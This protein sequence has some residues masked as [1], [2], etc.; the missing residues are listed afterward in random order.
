LTKQDV[1][2]VGS[3]TAVYDEAGNLVS[4]S[5]PRGL[6]QTSTYGR[7]GNEKT[8]QYA[9]DYQGDTKVVASWNIER[10]QAGRTNSISGPERPTSY[11]YDLQGRL[12]TAHDEFDGG[13]TNRSYGFDTNSNQ[14]SRITQVCD[15][16]CDGAS[17]TSESSWIFDAAN[18]VQSGSNGQ[19]GGYVY[20]GLGRQT[21]IPGIDTVTGSGDLSIAYYDNDLVAS[22]SQNVATS[23][24]TLDPAGRRLNQTLTVSGGQ[25]QLVR[26]YTDESDNPGWVTT[27]TNESSSV[28][29]YVS[30]IGGDLAA[31]MTDG[32]LVLNIVDPLGNVA[33]TLTSEGDTLTPGELGQWDEYGNRLT[34]HSAVS[35]PLT[36]GWLGGK[37]RA[38]D[39]TTGLVLMGSRLYNPVTG[40]FTSVDPVPGGNTTEYGYPQDPINTMDLDGNSWWSR[41]WQKVVAVVAVVA[42]ANAASF[43]PGPV[44]MISSGVAAVSYASLGQWGAVAA[45]A[46]AFIPGGKIMAMALKD[47]KAMRSIMSVQASSRLVGKQSKLFGVGS[48][49]GKTLNRG[50]GKAGLRIG[51][52]KY[53]SK[54]SWRA[55][56]RNN[57]H[58]KTQWLVDE[59]GHFFNH[60]SKVRWGR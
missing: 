6:T 47:G 16:A 43:I 60:T 5:T 25:T 33:T 13:C 36:Y 11:T 18:R 4:Q 32:V 52:S 48:K 49:F 23:T 28:T 40:L 38:V 19:G 8:L 1:S 10:D 15:D 57:P 56:M 30:S 50:G 55:G 20:D 34:A 46:V 14:T 22:T 24:F 31:S 21:V 9:V 54:A 37:E 44:G 42:V 26:H 45:S 3:Y 27:T 59:G 12:T 2:G 41:H 53:K 58:A 35:G 51:W 29:R 7:A 17:T 39:D